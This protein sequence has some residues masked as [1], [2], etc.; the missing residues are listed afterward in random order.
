[1]LECK[2]YTYLELSQYLHCTDIQGTERKLK[3]Y[4]IE[5]TASGRGKNRKYNITKITNPFKVFSVFE[6]GLDPHC[7][8]MKFAYFVYLILCDDTFN[9]MGAEMMEAYLRDK[10]INISR[11]TISKYIDYL[12]GCNLI[13]AARTNCVY[14]KVYK[15][16]G[17]QCHEDITRKEYAEAWKIYWECIKDGYESRA[18]YSTMYNAFGGVPRKH[19]LIELNVFYRD[20]TDWLTEL[21]LEEFGDVE[22]LS[23]SN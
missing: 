9:G 23:Q 5:Y 16:Y 6:V 1:M 10:P 15:R 18:A 11:Q 8:F 22:N 7:D 4:G 17:V 12:S 14:Y 21:L 19:P 13:S 2:T 20:I 3:S